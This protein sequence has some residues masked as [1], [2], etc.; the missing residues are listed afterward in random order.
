MPAQIALFDGFDPLGVIA[1]FEGLTA[2]GLITGPTGRRAATGLPG[3][4]A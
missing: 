1:P 3:A 4:S 2:G